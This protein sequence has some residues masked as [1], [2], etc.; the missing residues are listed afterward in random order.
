MAHGDRFLAKPGETIM[1]DDPIVFFNTQK[2]ALW[3]DLEDFADPKLL[4]NCLRNAIAI[5]DAQLRHGKELLFERICIH[6]LIELRVPNCRV[7]PVLAGALKDFYRD[8]GAEWGL[9]YKA[10]LQALFL[11][12]IRRKGDFKGWID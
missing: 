8:G 3:R 6:F 10:L 5:V 2:A 9:M 12:T 1:T 11:E 4:E 7:Y